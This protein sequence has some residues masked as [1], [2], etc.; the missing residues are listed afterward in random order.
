M[1]Y[2]SEYPENL[3]PLTKLQ[4]ECEG[5]VSVLGLG[6]G[7]ADV[8]RALKA[9][10]RKIVGIDVFEPYIALNRVREPSMEFILGDVKNVVDLLKGRQFDVVLLFDIVEHLEEED[11]RKLIDD[12]EKVARNKV[13]AFIPV[14]PCP[15]T[16]KQWIERLPD[17]IPNP[18]QIHRSIWYPETMDLRGN[19]VWSWTKFHHPR[20]DFGQTE[21][22]GAMFCVKEV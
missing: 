19:D 18:Y 12:A 8:L 21:R 3:P 16:D 6:C 17:Q 14:G 11:A 2:Q 5:N 10:G 4:K 20:V 22:F 15:Q 9:P 13:I 1:I 7:F